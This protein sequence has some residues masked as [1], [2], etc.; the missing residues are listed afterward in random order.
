MA[1]PAL[2]HFIGRVVDDVRR[3]DDGDWEIVLEGGVVI[4]SGRAGEMPE[5]T[6]IGKRFMTIMLDSNQTR[7][8]FT[9][10]SND[11]TTSNDA[12]T[13]VVPLSAMNYTIET[14][15]YDAFNPQQPEELSEAPEDPSEQRTNDGPQAPESDSDEAEEIRAAQQQRDEHDEAQGL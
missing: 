6:L 8:S 2:D 7:L 3:D 10:A 12:I 11:D 5:R 15:D 13:E 9:G 1:R 14:P 4:N